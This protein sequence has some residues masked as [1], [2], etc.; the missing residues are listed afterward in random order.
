MVFTGYV[1]DDPAAAEVER[2]AFEIFPLLAGS[3]SALLREQYAVAF[4]NVLGNPGEF[5]RFVTGSPGDRAARVDAL[6]GAF[7]ENTLLLVDKT[8]VEKHDEEL[9][10]DV[11][12]SLESFVEA[13]RARAARDAYPRFVALAKG[14]AKLLFGAHAAARDFSEYVFRID[15]KLGLFYWYVDELSKVE[16]TLDDPTRETLLLLGVF[17]IASF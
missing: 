16:P 3:D 13:F 8:W 5:S 7:R 2:A 6:V 15:P 10:A 12:F 17:F 1:T 4:A 14:L 11:A 9:K